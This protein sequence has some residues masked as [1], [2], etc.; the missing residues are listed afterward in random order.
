ML[1]DSIAIEETNTFI[2]GWRHPYWNIDYVMELEHWMKIY[3]S[4]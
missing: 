4:G 2:V 1:V 3:F